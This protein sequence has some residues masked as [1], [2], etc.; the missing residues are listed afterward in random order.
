[1]SPGGSAATTV[2]IAALNGF[3]GAVTFTTSVPTTLSGVTAT[4]GQ[5]VTGSGT[6]T[7]TITASQTARLLP[8]GGFN[9]PGAPVR[10][11]IVLILGLGAGMLW[12][13]SRRPQF[14]VASPQRAQTRMWLGLALICLLAAGVSCGGG[15]SSGGA[16]GN[17]TKPPETGSVTVTA[18]S[19]SL[20]HSASVSV[21]VN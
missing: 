3:K 19:G 6:T 20:S 7:L 18:G 11:A 15:N 10:L 12:L 2:T 1:M 5:S 9:D 21:T 8:R 14:G 13:G 4:T 16:S 17:T